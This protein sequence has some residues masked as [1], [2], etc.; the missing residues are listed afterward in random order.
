LFTAMAARFVIVASVGTVR[1]VKSVPRMRGAFI[2]HQSAKLL[3]P[4]A[5]PYGEKK[6]PTSVQQPHPPRR[7]R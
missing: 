7:A 5:S 1:F 4:S 2:R 6:F 3:R